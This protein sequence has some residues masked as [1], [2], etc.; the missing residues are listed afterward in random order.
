MANS[1][2][3]E[4]LY[5]D[6]TNASEREE[7]TCWK[8]VLEEVGKERGKD[9]NRE[10]VSLKTAI[11]VYLEA[12]S[13]YSNALFAR[14]CEIQDEL[15][16]RYDELAGQF[17]MNDSR[18]SDAG[19]KEMIRRLKIHRDLYSEMMEYI[20]AGKTYKKKLVDVAGYNAKKLC[21][22]Y[23]LS[24]GGA[25][26]FLIYMRE[27][28]KNA[29]EDLRR[30]R[31]SMELILEYKGLSLI[32][33]YNKYYIRFVG[34]LREGYPCDLA[35]TNKEAMSIIS[36]NEAMKNVID[37]YKK[38]VEWT[39]RYFINSFLADYMLYECNMSE[40]RINANMDKLNRHGDVKIELY[41]TLI[42]EKFPVAGAIKVCGYTAEALHRDY[43]LSPL[44]AYNYLVYL[45]ED[46]DNALACLQAGLPR[47]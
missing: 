30:G 31:N 2:A 14:M 27:D 28:E 11:R 41:E 45:K 43:D 20:L 39:S 6:I 17:I 38:K 46:P 22:E 40:K 25:Y 36:S 42:Y 12:S 4:K 37:E 26:N 3:I 7:G 34:G 29:L 47:K 35:I 23:D 10:Y 15:E 8:N 24:I 33:K 19:T 44:G 5:A 16:R 1:E 13:D 9:P 18:L 32:K 21:S